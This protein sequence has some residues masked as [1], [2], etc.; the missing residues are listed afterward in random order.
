MVSEPIFAVVPQTAPTHPTHAH[1]IKSDGIESCFTDPQGDY[2]EDYLLLDDCTTEPEFNT[3]LNQTK[4][5]RLT[6]LTN[7]FAF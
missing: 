1:S 3:T 6:K 5:S 2:V 7:R 4:K